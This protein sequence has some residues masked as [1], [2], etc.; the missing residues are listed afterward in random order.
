MSRLVQGHLLG[1]LPQRLEIALLGWPD[2]KALAQKLRGV[3]DETIDVGLFS[4]S[5]LL[6]ADD[7]DTLSLTDLLLA[8]DR[9]PEAAVA[10]IGRAIFEFTSD[11]SIEGAFATAI[12]PP[13]TD[14]DAAILAHPGAVQYVNDD[15]KSFLDC[16]GD[17]IYLATPIASV[18]GSLCL[19]VYT[20]LSRVK[21]LPVGELA[22]EA[23]AV[24]ARARGAESAEELDIADE[25]LDEILH[26]TLRDLQ[27]KRLT[28]E[29]LDVLRLAY[30][31]T[32]EWIKGRRRLLAAREKPA[33]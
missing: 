16:Y 26:E 27:A 23:L 31:Q 3:S 2:S 33:A 19:Y 15:E 20:R 8:R 25:R 1:G 4:V 30:E 9:L 5:P 14:K 13:D 22:E 17:W 28:A 10:E 18:I 24:A 11:L 12:E 32:R 29:G 6:P 7:L 21:P